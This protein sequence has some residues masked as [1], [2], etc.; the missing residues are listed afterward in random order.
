MNSGWKK[1]PV[2]G[3]EIAAAASRCKYCQEWIT[4]EALA[5]REERLLQEAA[6]KAEAERQ[7][8]V[9]EAAEADRLE[10]IRRAE[11]QRR[12]EAEQARL[13]AE[14]ERRRMA[15]ATAEEDRRRQAEM[16]RT[17]IIADQ[18]NIEFDRTFISDVIPEPQPAP[19][20]PVV[21]MPRSNPNTTPTSA[22]TPSPAV[23]LPPAIPQPPV[24]NDQYPSSGN[25]EKSTNENKEGFLYKY[26]YKSFLCHYV[27]FSGTISKKHYWLTYLAVLLVE[28]AL[29]GL[30]AF[31]AS[32]FAGGANLIEIYSGAYIALCVLCIAFFLPGLGLTIRRLRDQGK[33]WPWIFIVLIPYIGSFWLLILMLTRGGDDEED[34]TGSKFKL[35]DWASVVC[36][37]VFPILAF[38][39]GNAIHESSRHLYD[40]HDYEYFDNEYNYDDDYDFN[41]SVT[42]QAVEAPDVEEVVEEVVAEEVPDYAVVE[43]VVEEV[44][45]G[46]GEDYDDW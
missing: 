14:A 29:F 30:F 21:E 19:Q 7:R 36:A 33:S 9:A 17:E 42:P 26:F 1:C 31:I 25:F 43:E 3:R 16:S 22:P 6:Q 4:P 28:G 23:Q 15:A 24:V 20:S 8:L 18:Q 34:F 39:I 5:Q 45:D 46:S 38:I 12:Q 35:V 10:E 13:A 37:F 41:S 2:C 40:S 27:D 44:T 32:L 11:E